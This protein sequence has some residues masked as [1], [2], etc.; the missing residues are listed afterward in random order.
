M[1]S[2][3][4]KRREPDIMYLPKE[5]YNAIYEI[6]LPKVEAECNQAFRCNAWKMQK[7]DEIMGIQL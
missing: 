6:F 5:E 1:A 3:I 7:T 2:N 4:T